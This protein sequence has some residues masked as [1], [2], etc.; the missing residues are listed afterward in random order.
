MKYMEL[1]IVADHTLVRAEG[2]ENPDPSQSP[3]WIY[4]LTLPH[5]H[6]SP[7]QEPEPRPGPHQ[8]AHRGD[9]KL[10]G[11]GEG[12]ARALGTVPPGQGATELW[13]C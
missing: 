13:N 1:F 4:P 10:R 6:L 3:A 7:V 8:A 5:P 12:P 11:Q 9:R 2:A